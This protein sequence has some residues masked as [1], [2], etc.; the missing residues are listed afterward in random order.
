VRV[1]L[2][3][4]EG[5]LL[6]VVLHGGRELHCI[7]VSSA[8][9]VACLD[10]GEPFRHLSAGYLEGRPV[11]VTFSPHGAPRLHQLLAHRHFDE[12]ALPNTSLVASIVAMDWD[13]PLLVAAEWRRTIRIVDLQSGLQAE[14]LNE[15]FANPAC[16][17]FSRV[18]GHRMIAL[19]AEYGRLLVWR[20][21]RLI[22]GI[23]TSC[24][25]SNVAILPD[26]ALVVAGK[27]GVLVF[28][29]EYETSFN[30]R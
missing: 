11:F 14:T 20:D 1:A 28:E 5:R 26:G 23:D 30:A 6:A 4:A 25:I 18:K 8:K 9:E 24:T 29:L 27:E 15:D 10:L 3:Q 12:V 19:G 17:A 2:V 22:A 16:V 13:R 7:D 21:D